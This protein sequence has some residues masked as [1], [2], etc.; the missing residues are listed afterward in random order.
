MITPT[1]MAGA[2]A[3]GAGGAGGAAGGEPMKP[4]GSRWTSAVSTTGYPGDEYCIKPP[5]ADKGFQM[6]IGPD[7]YDEPRV[8]VRARARPRGQRDLRRRHPATRRRRLLLPPVPHAPR[9]APPDRQLGRRR[10]RLGGS[11]NSAKDNP[12]SGI[13]APENEGVGMAARPRAR[14]SSNSLHYLQL[15]EQTHHQGD[16]GQLLVPRRG[17]RDSSPRSRC[18]RSR[19]WASAPGQHVRDLG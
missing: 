11:T 5:P 7:D 10:T 16:L 3:G 18:S 9:L 12:E 6:H 13:I 4:P 2:A 14:S 19:R 17:R 1:P 8:A 15:H